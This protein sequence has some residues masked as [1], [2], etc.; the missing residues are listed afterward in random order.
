MRRI[1]KRYLVLA[2]YAAAVL[3]LAASIRWIPEVISFSVPLQVALPGCSGESVHCIWKQAHGMPVYTNSLEMPFS[4]SFFNWL[5]YL[6]Y[7][8]VAKSV[9]LYAGLADEWIPTIS[10]G[11]SL[12]FACVGALVAT[13]LFLLTMPQGAAQRVWLSVSMGI[14]AFFGPMLIAW[15][16]SPRPDVGALMLETA[17]MLAVLLAARRDSVWLE[18]GIYVLASLL[19]FCA[20]GFRVINIGC[21]CGVCLWL[22]LN[23]RIR[24]L[25]A[26]ALPF[27]LLCGLALCLGSSGWRAN[28]LFGSAVSPFGFQF[29]VQTSV[30]AWVKNPFIVIAFMLLLSG[31]RKLLHERAGHLGLWFCVLAVSSAIALATSFKEGSHQNYWFAAHLAALGYVAHVWPLPSAERLGRRLLLIGWLWTGAV[32][33]GYWTG[34]FKALDTACHARLMVLKA[35]L[36]GLPGPVLVRGGYFENLP[37]I[38]GQTEPFVYTFTYHWLRESGAVFQRGGLGGLA[39]EG[40][41]GTI[42]YPLEFRHDAPTDGAPLTRYQESKQDRHFRYFVRQP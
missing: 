35:G 10:A 28:A 41:F 15:N 31:W 29:G 4:S 3:C 34:K 7:G 36:Q 38:T 17:G 9:M 5:H 8:G 39:A 19:F 20:W 42:V 25:C 2:C 1:K 37:W 18:V 23:G 26:V 30:L 32:Q 11:L 6:T 40:Y 14:V 33:F 24:C 16:L 21:L 13:C 12:T 27:G 22:L